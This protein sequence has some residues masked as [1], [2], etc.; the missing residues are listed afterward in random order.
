MIGHAPTQRRHPS[1][2]PDRRRPRGVARWRGARVGGKLTVISRGAKLELKPQRDGTTAIAKRSASKRQVGTRIEIGFGPAL[3]NDPHAL[4]WAEI[5]IVLADDGSSYVGQS[6]P[7][8]YDAPQFHELLSAS[9][10][11]SLRALVA[12]RP[13]A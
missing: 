2:P 5:A 12:R 11:T 8:W 7:Y 9:G 3:P 4:H 10:G 6:S 1:L 13:R